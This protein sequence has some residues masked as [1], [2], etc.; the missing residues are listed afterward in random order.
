MKRLAIETATEACSVALD[1]GGEV[2]VRAETGPRIHGDRLLPW[3]H[4]LLAEAGVGIAGLDA[5]VVDRGPGGFT[6]LRIGIGVAQGL[7]LAAGLPIRPVSSLAATAFDAGAGKVMAVLD[8]RMDQVYAAGYEVN[9]NNVREIHPE[10]VCDP[11]DL[12]R[13]ETGWHLAGTGAERHGGAVLATTGLDDGAVIV[14]VRPDARVLLQLADNIAAI[15]GEYL[16][17]VYLRDDVA[18]RAKDA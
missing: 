18:H 13:L 17:P 9:G 8:A 3:V 6:S 11:G 1:I 2:T 5:L 15:D 7:A 4:E 14:G 12:P 16:E 10:R